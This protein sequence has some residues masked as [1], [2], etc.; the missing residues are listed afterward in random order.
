MSDEDGFGR[1]N[2]SSLH[3]SHTPP[4]AGI[5]GPFIRQM[6]GLS[7]GIAIAAALG[8]GSSY[9]MKRVG[10]SLDGNFQQAAA[11]GQP[12]ATIAAAGVGGDIALQRAHR[13]CTDSTGTAMPNVP[14]MRDEWLRSAEISVHRAAAYSACLTTERPQRFCNKSHRQ[15]LVKSV[16][17]YLNVRR[18]VREEWSLQG[19]G[20]PG[21]NNVMRTGVTTSEGL[22]SPVGSPSAQFDPQLRDGLRFLA[23][24]GLV[25]VSDFGG[26]A[27]F[28]TPSD[29][30]EAM[31][32]VEAGKD[33]CT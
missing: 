14:P 29:V 22:R 33:A 11:R 8:A 6:A 15:H 2:R 32:G 5:G 3:T 30:V 13:T 19:G 18:R 31:K 9:V 20:G 17:D 27:G 10:R 1:E 25:N 23:G 28:G 4:P 21:L 16:Q 26:F 24:R 12:T 7:A